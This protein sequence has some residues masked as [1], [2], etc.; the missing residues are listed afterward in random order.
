VCLFIFS[1]NSGVQELVGISA[2]DFS[3]FVPLSVFLDRYRR[4]VR[5]SLKL[6]TA[7]QTITEVL[8]QS[9]SELRGCAAI[10]SVLAQAHTTDWKRNAGATTLNRRDRIWPQLARPVCIRGNIVVPA[11]KL[12]S[13]ELFFLPDSVLVVSRNSIAALHYRDL[14]FSN[15]ATTFIEDGRAPRDALVVGQTWRFVN[16]SGGPDRRFNFNRQ[17][18]ACRY[19]EM[20]F[21]SAGGLNGKIHFSN[22]SAGEKFARAIEILI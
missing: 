12:G 15:A 3:I 10:W 7:A 19:G 14:R 21:S 16:K 17:L 6:N 22:I 13:A 8:S 5:V 2:L 20:D 11:I 4:S 9:F 18:P 1:I